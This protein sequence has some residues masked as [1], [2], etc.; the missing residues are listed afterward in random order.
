MATST[1][2]QYYGTGKRKCSIARVYLRPGSGEIKINKRPFEEYFGTLSLQNQVLHPFQVANAVNQYDVM[3]NAKGGGVSGQQSEEEHLHGVGGGGFERRPPVTG[4]MRFTREMNAP[5]APSAIPITISH[6]SVPRRPSSHQPT[7]PNTRK[8]IANCSPAPAYWAY[9]R[10]GPTPLA[11]R[12]RSSGD[13][14]S[15]GRR[16]GG[17]AHRRRIQS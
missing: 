3:I 17:Q 12:L 13:I 11:S 1:K 15:L 8:V 16:S 10:L 7:N 5:V 4:G 14:A 9:S 2:T 6:G